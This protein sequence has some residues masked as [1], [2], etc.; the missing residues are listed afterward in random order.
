MPKLAYIAK[1]EIMVAGLVKVSKKVEEKSRQI[2]FAVSKIWLGALRFKM[3]RK[4]K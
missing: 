4:P 1:N 2:E 3:V